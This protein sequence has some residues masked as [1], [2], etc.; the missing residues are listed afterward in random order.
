MLLP[1]EK[2][3]ASRNMRLHTVEKD[4]WVSGMV[5]KGVP[6]EPFE[7]QWIQYLVRPGDVAAT[8]VFLL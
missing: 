4:I 8:S 3:A 6:Y 1:H 5:A 7:T 2:T